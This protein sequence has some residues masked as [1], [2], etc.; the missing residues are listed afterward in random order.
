ME[1]LLLNLYK[2]L[3]NCRTVDPK[4]KPRIPYLSTS[5]HWLI[6][7]RITWLPP[8]GG[9]IHVCP[10]RGFVYM[11]LTWKSKNYKPSTDACFQHVRRRSRNSTT[12][13]STS[14]ITTI[15]GV[16]SVTSLATA[17]MRMVKHYRTHL[18]TMTASATSNYVSWLMHSRYSK[19][20]ATNRCV[21]GLKWCIHPEINYLLTF[22]F[23][24]T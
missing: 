20:T 4:T 10:E 6:N 17:K 19:T 5:S 14:A 9:F 22:I 11:Y 23:V 15:H 18:N 8:I 12:G 24:L 3:H 2:L 21:S 7:R 13:V 16:S 1:W